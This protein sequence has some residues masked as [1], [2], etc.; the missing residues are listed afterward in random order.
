MKVPNMERNM[1]IY[2]GHC[3]GVRLRDIA[4]EENITPTRAYQIISATEY[5]LSKGNPEYWEA[6]KKATGSY[7]KI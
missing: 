6:Y 3:R 7:S 1:R 2:I 5:Q 4:G